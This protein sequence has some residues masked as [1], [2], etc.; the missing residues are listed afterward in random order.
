MQVDTQIDAVSRSVTT[1]ERDGEQLRSQSLVQEYPS[2]ID[3]VWEATTTADR[4]ARWFMP[5]EGDLRVGGRYQLIGNAG[6]TVEECA[7]PHDGQAS[8][9]VTWEFGGGVSWLE[10]ALEANGPAA[11]V[12]RL[13]HT[14]KVAD[15]PPG[16]WETYGPGATGVG[17]DSGLL[18]LGMHLAGGESISPEDAEAWMLSDE[19]KAF[20]RAAADAWAAAQ[21][22]DGDDP[23]AAG[24]AADATFAFYTGQAPA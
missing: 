8:Y 7:P 22:A 19:G 18:G 21:V 11:T 13:T 16:F 3:D 2:D 15:V 5:V 4:I 10:I 9:R 17:W 12:L 24:R 1:I 20:A 6:G 23:D 14:A